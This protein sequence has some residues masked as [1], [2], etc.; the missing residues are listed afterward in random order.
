MRPRPLSQSKFLL[1]FF[2]SR[3]ISQGT[4]P[5]TDVIHVGRIQQ[6]FV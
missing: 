4:V 6:R 1:L 5:L 2:L 3:L